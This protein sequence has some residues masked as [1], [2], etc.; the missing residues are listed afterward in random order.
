[1]AS[2]ANEWPRM[3][4]LCNANLMNEESASNHYMGKKHKNK[5]KA[6]TEVQSSDRTETKQGTSLMDT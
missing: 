4:L 2:A 6:A 5:V 3:C 1:M